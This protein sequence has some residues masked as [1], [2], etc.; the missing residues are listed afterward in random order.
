MIIKLNK[1]FI[2][3]NQFKLKCTVGKGGIKKKIKEGDKITPKGTYFLGKLYYRSDRVGKFQTKLDYKIIKKNMGWSDDPKSSYYNRQILIKK[4]YKFSYEKLYRKDHKY[5]FVI[6]IKY[7][8]KKTVK[9][10]GS[11][12]FLHLTKNYKPT[13]GCIALKKKDF[14]ILL[15]LINKKTRIKII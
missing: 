8:Y 13:A 4:N 7:N 15:N 14:L 3:I 10:K 11:A 5:D 12:I 9:N 1:N 6:P 2:C